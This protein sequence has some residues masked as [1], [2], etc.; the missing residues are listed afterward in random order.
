MLL[1]QNYVIHIISPH[2]L[3]GVYNGFVSNLRRRSDRKD[4]L[5]RLKKIL[6]MIREK[7]TNKMCKDF[8]NQ[9]GLKPLPAFFLPR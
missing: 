1:W 7:G 5:P 2:S 9:K 4:R 6:Q 3:F 8:F